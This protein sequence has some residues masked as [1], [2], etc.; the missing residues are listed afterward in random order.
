MRRVRGRSPN[1][2]LMILVISEHVVIVH[3]ELTRR[4]VSAEKFSHFLD[5]L[6]VVLAHELAF[7]IMDNAPVDNGVT[8]AGNQQ[9]V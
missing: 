3:Y 2:N 1:L 7:V 8:F 6:E 4:I 5:N 9:Q